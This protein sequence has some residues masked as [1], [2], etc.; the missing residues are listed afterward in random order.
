MGESFEQAI[1]E[2]L[3]L[4]RRNSRL[5]E[6]QPL[7]AYIGEQGV[8]DVETGSEGAAFDTAEWNGRRP[9]GKPDSF[10]ESLEDVWSSGPVFDWGDDRPA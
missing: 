3:D 4:K 5:E 9:R 8:F 6:S 2:H 1:R 10:R 7:S